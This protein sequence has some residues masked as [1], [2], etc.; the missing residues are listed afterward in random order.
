MLLDNVMHVVENSLP[1]IHPDESSN[2][3]SIHQPL[4]RLKNVSK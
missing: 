3:P 1:S 4:N 2:N